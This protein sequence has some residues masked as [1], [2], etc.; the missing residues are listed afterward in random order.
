MAHSSDSEFHGIPF[1]PNHVEL[2]SPQILPGEMWELSSPHMPRGLEPV[3]EPPNSSE[4][5]SP[6]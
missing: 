6:T 4:L 1:P 2:P 3:T 5:G